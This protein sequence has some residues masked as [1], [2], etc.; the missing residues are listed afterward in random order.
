MSALEWCIVKSMNYWSSIV[1]V[2][3]SPVTIWSVSFE[4]CVYSG[5]CSCIIFFRYFYLAEN[6]YRN[7]LFLLE[8]KILLGV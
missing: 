3:R 7:L 8:M 2:M 6:F 4:S 1:R 5:A